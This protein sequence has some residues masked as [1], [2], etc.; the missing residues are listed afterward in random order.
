MKFTDVFIERVKKQE[1]R[2]KI[3]LEAGETFTTVSRWIKDKSELITQK[4][5]LLAIQKVTGLKEH[6]I[7]ILE[8]TI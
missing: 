8:K 1:V 7:F 2:M 5:V 4:R 3:A 6:E